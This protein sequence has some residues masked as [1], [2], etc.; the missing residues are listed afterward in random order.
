MPGTVT[1]GVRAAREG[2]ALRLTVVDD[3]PG[4]GAKGPTGSGVGLRNIR[5]R[6][7]ALYGEAAG[8]SLE[9]GPDQLT[10]A[11]LVLPLRAGMPS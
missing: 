2:Q 4:P 6:L 8:L 1:V 5:E 9:R 11:E 10:R 7:R 3:G